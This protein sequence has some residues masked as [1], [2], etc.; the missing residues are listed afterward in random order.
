MSE[1]ASSSGFGLS[2]FGKVNWNQALE[3][4]ARTKA[5][6]SPPD[7]VH[8]PDKVA[9]LLQKSEEGELL[10]L[11]PAGVDDYLRIFPALVRATRDPS[12][13]VDAELLND[14]CRAMRAMA[15][16]NSPLNVK[17]HRE[18]G[19][20]LGASFISAEVAW[21]ARLDGAASRT[22]D[23]LG[24][25]FEDAAHARSRGDFDTSRLSRF[26]ATRELNDLRLAPLDGIKVEVV[27]IQGNRRT[28]RVIS[29]R[30]LFPPKLQRTVIEL[31][32][33]GIGN[34]K[35]PVRRLP[36]GWAVH[37]ELADYLKR[38]DLLPTASLPVRLDD[39]FPGHVESVQRGTF[40][41]VWFEGV[42]S[43]EWAEVLL[44]HTPGSVIASTEVERYEKYGLTPRSRRAGGQ[45]ASM[46]LLKGWDGE[47]RRE[48]VTSQE[49]APSVKAVLIHQGIQDAVTGC[50]L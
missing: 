17:I 11:G 32:M 2:G 12:A 15:Q 20:P 7:S 21:R 37:G 35:S 16:R 29:D 28:F 8:S 50:D 10:D 5:P 26:Q 36:N 3:D 48:L 4:A 14:Y 31:S 40:G 13:F 45:G 47:R 25:L 22:P 1:G 18:T 46:A 49:I 38:A 9:R 33:E 23:Q 43:P 34:R 27:D 6:A 39:M 30:V 24:D 42:S 19:C 44:Q 41:P